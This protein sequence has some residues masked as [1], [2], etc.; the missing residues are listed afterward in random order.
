MQAERELIQTEFDLLQARRSRSAVRQIIELCRKVDE[1]TAPIILNFLKFKG[2]PHLAT[3][4]GLE[5]LRS[6][7]I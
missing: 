4:E 2:Y 7:S 5:F 3:P 1:S 6:Q